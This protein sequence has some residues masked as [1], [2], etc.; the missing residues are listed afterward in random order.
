MF[1]ITA[2]CVHDDLAP[3]K[4]GIALRAAD[5]KTACRIDI[6]LCLRA[7]EKGYR[8]VCITK[9]HLNHKE[10][11]QKK[12]KIGFILNNS[13]AQSTYYKIRNTILTWNLYPQYNHNKIAFYKY[14]IVYRLS[15]II[16]EKNTLLKCK[17]I[18]TGLIHGHLSR[19]GIYDI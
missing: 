8:I 1:G 17:A 2:V 12:T 15:K 4:P 19:S 18:F 10:G 9:T 6:E 7:I 3:G 14:H 11:Y 13:S 16:F 5:H